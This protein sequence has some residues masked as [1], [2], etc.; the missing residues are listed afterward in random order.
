MDEYAA[1]ADLYDHVGLY[2]DRPDVEFFVEAA[3]EAGGPVLELGS[4]TGRILI[5]T[6]REGI[7]ITGLDGSPSMLA[8]CRERVAIEP[9]QVRDRITTVE[10]DMRAFDLAPRYSLVTL[11]FRPFQHLVT[12]D[13]QLACL[14]AARRHLVPGGRL[15]LDLFNPMLEVLAG[16]GDNAQSEPEFV[17]GDG[18]RV[19][20]HHRILS[21]DR[22][23][24]VNQI[25]IVYAITHPDGRA[26]RLVHQFAMRYL[27][28]YEAE[29]LLARAGFTVEAVYSDYDKRPFGSKYPG[30]LLLVAR[31]N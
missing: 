26:E 31:S 4:G 25:E 11:P 13:D 18:R 2:R 8:V 15:V 24:Q 12:V 30:E 14:S 22:V 21:R 1:I 19:V 29:H 5:P 10:S 3:R 28:R 27:F 7:A 17:T 23:A 6:A 20:R 16:D 9:K